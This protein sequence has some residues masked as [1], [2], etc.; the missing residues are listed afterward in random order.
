ME[1]ISKPAGGYNPAAEANPEKVSS[2]Q[3]TSVVFFLAVLAVV[4]PLRNLPKCI[5]IFLSLFHRKTESRGTHYI[6]VYRVSNVLNCKR[7]FKK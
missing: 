2:E 7:R 3:K 4:V 1:P 6:V 5:W